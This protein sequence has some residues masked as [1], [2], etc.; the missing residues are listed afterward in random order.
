MDFDENYKVPEEI[1]AKLT[2]EFCK[3]FRRELFNIHEYYHLGLAADDGPIQN[4]S[5]S[6]F[7][8]ALWTACMKTGREDLFMYRDGLHWW[9]SDIFDDYLIQHMMANHYL[10]GYMEDI[11]AHYLRIP[12]GDLRRC[13]ECGG[14]FT[15]D[16]GKE[17]EGEFSTEWVCNTC[18]GDSGEYYKEQYAKMDKWLKKKQHT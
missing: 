16:M 18:L 1:I 15:K 4:T 7:V 5:T 11:L 8:V 3:A 14:W 6:G 17:R 10:L 2:D 13:E 12:A 9:A